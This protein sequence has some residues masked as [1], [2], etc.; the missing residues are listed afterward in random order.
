MALDERLLNIPL[1]LSTAAMRPGEATDEALRAHVEALSRAALQ[2]FADDEDRLAFQRLTGMTGFLSADRVADGAEL[3]Q[4][5][6]AA[7][8]LSLGRDVEKP[9]CGLLVYSHMAP[10]TRTTKY[11]AL[12]LAHTHF[13]PETVP[14]GVSQA[15]G[16]AWVAGLELALAFSGDL[17]PALP[18]V[19]L[20]AS[21]LLRPPMARRH[22]MHAYLSDAASTVWLTP[23]ST[24]ALWCVEKARVVRDARDLSGD[25]G[26]T[27]AVWLERILGALGATAATRPVGL[28]GL[29]P[30]LRQSLVQAL[31]QKGWQAF[32][33][34][35]AHDLCNS[36]LPAAL[37]A[38]NAH[39]KRPGF[40]QLRLI[41]LCI[42][43][44]L[45]VVELSRVDVAQ[46]RS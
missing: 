12:A 30:I 44:S 22:G 26:V 10:E 14:L 13:P 31:G 27:E 24:G 6:V 3:A 37:L 43:N 25:G 40:E 38:L 5:S 9:A 45:G 17:T 18:G 16:N 20:V 23:T 34:G 8:C 32:D 11:P 35:S 4:E 33:A 36:N 15:G 21:D 28:T 7:M 46:E 1:A 29:N 39:A 41:N 42:G 2:P 19:A